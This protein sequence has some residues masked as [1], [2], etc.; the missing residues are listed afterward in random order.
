VLL[1]DALGVS[2]SEPSNVDSCM[3]QTYKTTIV[4]RNVI[5]RVEPRP[6]VY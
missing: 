2:L 3:P 5:E 6:S 1:C 4:R